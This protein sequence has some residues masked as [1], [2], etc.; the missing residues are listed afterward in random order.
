M[1]LEYILLMKDDRSYTF[2]YFAFTKVSVKTCMCNGPT[3]L[4][5]STVMCNQSASK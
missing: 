1:H 4:L 5:Y 2:K 3:L